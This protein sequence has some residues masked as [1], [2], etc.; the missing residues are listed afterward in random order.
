MTS[1][2][3]NTTITPANGS[4]AIDPTHSRIGFAVR[5]AM[6]SKV[7][8]SFNEFAGSGHFDLADPSNISLALTI[9]VASLDTRNPD[10]DGHVLTADFLDAETFPEITFASTSVERRDESDFV[11]TGDLTIKDVTRPVVIDFEYGG[12]ATDLYGAQRI[13]F[14]GS[15]TISRKEWGVS[16]NAPLET[17]GVI[18][19]DKVALEF[20]VSAVLSDDAT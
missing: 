7:R 15:T 5:H 4:Y 10:R 13:G 20:E 12:T 8:G 11:V 1:T 17:G 6:I 16:F 2:D 9:Q 3:T 18:V 19:S 14:E